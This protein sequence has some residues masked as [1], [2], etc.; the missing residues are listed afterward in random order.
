MNTKGIKFLAVLAVLAMAF[1][2]F[3]VISDNSIQESD[4]AGAEYYSPGSSTPDTTLIVTSGA[5]S[6]TGKYVITANASITSSTASGTATVY[7]KTNAT[8]TIT[9]ISGSGSVTVIPVDENE[10]RLSLTSGVEVVYTSVSTSASF[11]AVNTKAVE[12]GGTATVSEG[13]VPAGAELIIKDGRLNINCAAQKSFVNDGKITANDSTIVLNAGEIKTS[14]TSKGTIEL[15][16]TKISG[17]DLRPIQITKGVLQNQV[18]KVNKSQTASKDDRAFLQ[19]STTGTDVVTVQ[20]NVFEMKATNGIRVYNDAVGTVTISNNKFTSEIYIDQCIMLAKSTT[21]GL[22]KVTISGNDFSGIK[23]FA[24]QDPDASDG[25]K[26]KYGKQPVQIAGDWSLVKDFP[27]S[28]TGA[29]IITDAQAIGVKSNSSDGTPTLTVAADASVKTIGVNAEGELI[30]SDGKTLTFDGIIYNKGKVTGEGTIT[31]TGMIN[32]YGELFVA[33]SNIHNV[34]CAVNLYGGSTWKYAGEL[35]YATSNTTADTVIMMGESA[36]TKYVSAIQKNNSTGIESATFDIFAPVVLK[37]GGWLSGPEAQTVNVKS[38]ASIDIGAVE[39]TIYENDVLNF[40]IGAKFL[41]TAKVIVNKDATINYADS[42]QY[43]TNT[44]IKTGGKIVVVGEG[45]STPETV[46]EFEPSGTTIDVT[47]FVDADVIIVSKT[48]LTDV[49]VP[50]G[51]AVV[52]SGKPD[53]TAVLDVSADNSEVTVNTGTVAATYTVKTGGSNSIYLKDVTGSLSFK[54]GSVEIDISKWTGG[55]IKLDD[56]AVVKIFGTTSATVDLTIS[57]KNAGKTATLII[58]EDQ[59]VAIDFG[60]S[61]KAFIIGEGIDFT[62]D[63]KLTANK[64]EIN[65]KLTVNGTVKTTSLVVETTK[66]VDVYGTLEGAVSTTVANGGKIV[67]YEAS[68]INMVTAASA[69]AYANF[70]GKTTSGG[71][72][73]FDGT[74]KLTLTNYAGNYN[75]TQIKAYLK[76][77][78]LEGENKIT[79]SKAITTEIAL[80]GAA[81]SDLDIKTV[82]GTGS[83]EVAVDLSKTTGAHL[84]AGFIVFIGKAVKLDTV[85]LKVTISGSNAEWTDTLTKAMAVS[86]IKASGSFTMKDSVAIIDVMSSYVTTKATAIGVDATSNPVNISGSSLSVTSAGAGII[87]TNYTVTGSVIGLNGK[88]YGLVA[89]DAEAN[90]ISFSN[91]AVG[92]SG[93]YAIVNLK[94]GGISFDGCSAVEITGKEYAM[95][96]SGSIETLTPKEIEGKVEIRNTVASFGGEIFASAVEITSGANVKVTGKLNA[97]DVDLSQASELEVKNLVIRAPAATEKSENNGTIIINGSATIVGSMTNK[98]TLTN[99]GTMGIY[100]TLKNET[101]GVFTNDGTLTVFKKELDFDEDKVFELN[102]DARTDDN[103]AKLSKIT[104]DYDAETPT[105]LSLNADGSI[106]VKGAILTFDQDPLFKAK[107]LDKFNGT[108]T[109]SQVDDGFTMT[110]SNGTATVV[111]VYTYDPSKA[112]TETVA[113]NVT[114]TV[115]GVLVDKTDSTKVLYLE[116]NKSDKTLTVKT[117]SIKNMYEADSQAA[118]VLTSGKTVSTGNVTIWSNY[119]TTLAAQVAVFNGEESEY[120]GNL[121][122]ELAAITLDGTFKGDLVTNGTGLTTIAG[123]MIGDV[124][125]KG[126]VLVSGTYVG[127]VEI[128]LKAPLAAKLTVSGKMLGDLVYQSSYKAASADTTDTVAYATMTIG[129]DMSVALGE[130]PISFEINLAAATNATT[131]TAGTPGYFTFGT[132]QAPVAGKNVVISLDQGMIKVPASVTIPE[133][134]QVIIEK[135][136]T[137]EVVKGAVLDVKKSALKVSKDAISHFETGSVAVTY[138]L[139]SCVMSF[140]IEEGAYTIYSDVAYALTMCDEGAELTVTTSADIADNVAVKKGV[141]VIIADK[142]T[143]DF[144][145]FGLAMDE[146]AKITLMGTGKVVFGQ[147]GEDKTD[148]SDWKFFTISGTIVYDDDAIDLNE[149]RFDAAGAEF[150]GKAATST[151]ASKISVKLNYSEGTATLTAGNGTGTVALGNTKYPLEKGADDTLVCGVFVIAADAV[152]DATSI[153]DAFSVVDY[154]K[155]AEDTVAT[156]DKVVLMPTV[157]SVEG[158]LNLAASTTVKGVYVGQG[159]INLAAGKSFS[160]AQSDAVPAAA[161]TNKTIPGSVAA[162]IVDT[163]DDQNGYVFNLVSPVPGE[164]IAINAISMKIEGVTVDVMTIS[165]NVKVGIITAT[166]SAVVNGLTLQENSAI[167]GDEVFIVG[168]SKAI[169]AVYAKEIH[170]KEDA[171]TSEFSTLDY[172]VTTAY[173]GY[174]VYTYFN[175]IDFEDDADIT[176]VKG[177]IVIDEKLD[178]SGKDVNIVIGEKATFTLESIL[179]IGTPTTVIGDEGSSIVGKITIIEDA[180]AYLVAY[181]DVDLTLAEIYGDDGKTDAVFSKL[182]IEDVVYAAIFASNQDAAV[183]DHVILAKA[184]A[185]II[186]EIVGYNF[187]SWLNYNGDAKAEVGE[188]NAYADA[189]A[190]YVTVMVKY[191]A[192]VDYYMNGSLFDALNVYT[193][194]PYGS[195]F[196]AKISDTSKYQGNPLVNGE[197]TVYVIDDMEIVASGVTPIPEPPAPEPVIG[198]SGISLTDILLIVLVVLI[199]IM[200]VILV[201][202]LNRS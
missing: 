188:T 128:D 103:K 125:A 88:L 151:E 57:M 85:A 127:D 101:P 107:D 109:P 27:T 37:K 143:L 172:Q 100:G 77:I 59:E 146:G 177:D 140:A 72:W 76:T 98:A 198:D 112:G 192:G 74:D 180:K 65:D 52:I 44:E 91:S 170:M 9:S 184:D 14:S 48:G 197:K 104:L 71:L 28:G 36:T 66:A 115:S 51:K 155:G 171:A 32:N 40:E 126:N 99:K 135:D 97:S 157:V 134:F 136:S 185:A 95:V 191:V 200:V 89:N 10:K 152:F 175:S 55:E 6:D 92:I 23:G 174:T 19:I 63:G 78:V 54:K 176:I 162:K 4:A 121:T 38:G 45:G 26:A 69:A 31:G 87:G 46:K 56:D 199:A 67:A 131:T 181:A 117:D 130:T 195:Y 64:V 42:S 141:N 113:D 90:S 8:L 183:A 150:T 102:T 156:I 161:A 178:L 123:F 165:G 75:F 79:Y 11:K 169:G 122:S 186:P 144:K 2:V 84:A 80:F 118:L 201:L 190:T 62:V 47:S 34:L 105:K 68:D 138:G 70:S 1:A 137:L 159:V 166:T 24:W 145:T 60:V 33:K 16:A 193:D 50:T 179:I 158:T 30:V 61:G 147:T 187:T 116:S 164:T 110:L 93:K 53:V 22:A 154:K 194:V 5:I 96:Q 7:V 25:E 196:T 29:F 160:L 168:A 17:E 149:V 106:S 21:T 153:T 173:E 114:I 167:L 82:Q 139:V 3:A 86:A 202:R 49:T 129:A 41:G 133:R 81:A 94:A 12:L 58:E 119:N 13:K 189:K 73:A 120:E 163:T 148:D 35:Y 20:D 15:N 142:V 108:I 18:V 132:L 39:T 111:V 182:D 43:Y 83:L 124:T